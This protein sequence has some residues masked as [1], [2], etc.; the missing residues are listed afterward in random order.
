[1]S[2]ELYYIDNTLKPIPVIFKKNFNIFPV[3]LVRN[4]QLNM[5]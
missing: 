5:K 3:K 1:M 2:E 4:L